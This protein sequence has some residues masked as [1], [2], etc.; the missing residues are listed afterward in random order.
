M[1]QSQTLPVWLDKLGDW[2]P[3]LLRE[4]KGRLSWRSVLLTVAL[5]TIVQVLLMMNYIQQIPTEATIGFN[6]KY[7]VGGINYSQARII[8]A[9]CVM[10]WPR[11]WRDIFNGQ[12]TSILFLIYLPAVYFLIADINQEIQ[13][14]T[15]N[16]LRLSPRSSQ[17]TLLGKLLGVPSLTYL[18]LILVIPLHF[19][20]GTMA[21]ISPIFS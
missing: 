1:R 9:N 15:I 10:D 20:C 6:T 18:A 17:T 4:I 16:F 7:C 5:V 19:L 11:W 2:N 3:Q 14:G 13:R 12:N 8:W 21:G